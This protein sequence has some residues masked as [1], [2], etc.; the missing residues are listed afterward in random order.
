MH[1]NK[2]QFLETLLI[3]DNQIHNLKLHNKRMNKTI[4]EYF[5]VDSNIDLS[6]HINIIDNKTYRCRIIYD[7][8][9][10]SVELVPY[11]KTPINS[12]EII[13]DDNIDYS[14][15]YLDRSTIENLKNQTTCDDIIIVKNNLITDTSIANIA[16]KLDDIWYTPKKPL[17]KGIM[18]ELLIKSNKL[19]EK[20]I[21]VKLF[22]SA[23]EFAI[24]NSLR[25]F[26][27]ITNPII[28]DNKNA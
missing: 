24:M 12:F 18:R 11:K 7:I 17:L 1:S 26:D 14:L 20:D 15:K 19:I 8:S 6:K 28:K 5:E 13:E 23:Q 22:K 10:I 3:K 9:V 4:E 21:S 2:T 16:I 27:I 25:R